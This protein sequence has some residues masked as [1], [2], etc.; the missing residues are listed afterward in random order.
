MADTKMI[1]ENF[2]ISWKI[3]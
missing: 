3:L 1:I 2:R